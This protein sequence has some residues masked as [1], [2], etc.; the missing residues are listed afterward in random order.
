MNYQ[1]DM[2][3]YFLNVDN[4]FDNSCVFYTYLCDVNLPEDDKKKIETCRSLGTL[5]VK[6][7]F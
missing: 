4:L 2:N 3:F 6:L 1:K 7:Y 5:C